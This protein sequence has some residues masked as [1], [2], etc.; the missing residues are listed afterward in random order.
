MDTLIEVLPWLSTMVVLIGCSAFFSASE[1]AFF[2]LRPSDQEALRRGG[3]AQR[4]AARLLNDPE[5]LLSAILFWNL[6]SNITYFAI[7]SI[8]TLQLEDV[9]GSVAV[10]FALGSLLVIIFFS[11][12]VPKT[13][14][15]LVARRLAALVSLPLATTVRA[16]DPLMPVLRFVNLVSRRLVLPRFQEETGLELGDLERAIELSTSDAQLIEQERTVLRNIV[17]LSDIRVDEWMRPRTQFLSFRPPVSLTDLE[18]RM[19]PSGYLLVTENDSEEVAAAINLQNVYSLSQQDLQQQAEAVICIPWCATVASALQQMQSQDREVAAV[20]NEFGE[21]IG[22]LTHEDLL[23]TIF[24]YGPSRSKRLLDRN[25]IHY[26]GPG[27]WLVAGV[28][29]LRRLERYVDLQ[30]PP[31]K[32]VTVGGIIQEQLGRLALP[33]DTCDW[34]TFHFRVLEVAQRGHM[35]V[36]MTH[37]T[38]MRETT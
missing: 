29:S 28:T 4:R 36:E 6:V 24:T 11:E 3:Q 19:T 33:E 35:I 31:R 25:P 13:L 2:Y 9:G 26:L 30:F 18:G 20:V 7:V 8:V 38:E 1:A 22:I 37:R 5:R 10:T 21:T 32:S 15:V 23:D 27:K 12:M 16:A 34:G 14:A 17:M